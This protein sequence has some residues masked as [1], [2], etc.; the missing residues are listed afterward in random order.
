MIKKNS[1]GFIF[2]GLALIFFTPYVQGASGWDDHSTHLFYFQFLNVFVLFGTLVYFLKNAARDFF[3]VRA[4]EYHSEALKAQMLLKQAQDQLNELQSNLTRVETTWSE[5]LSRAEAEAVEMRSRL[6]KQAEDQAF[7]MVEDAKK[8]M[9][10]EQTSLSQKRVEDLIVSVRE[11]V[12]QK[13][14]TD[15]SPQDHESLQ[16][17]FNHSLESYSL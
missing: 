12:E 14:Q 2:L 17:N 7:R 5:S 10:V 13:L 11:Q 4:E 9:L 6:S 3:K 8:A 16:K 15:L 1:M